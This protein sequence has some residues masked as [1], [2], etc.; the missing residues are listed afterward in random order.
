M[1]EIP[2]FSMIG[3]SKAAEGLTM[4]PNGAWSEP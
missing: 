2:R 3:S 4:L 1:I